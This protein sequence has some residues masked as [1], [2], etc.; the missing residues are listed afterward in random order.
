MTAPSVVAQVSKRTA[1]IAQ[2]QPGKNSYESGNFTQAARELQA[3]VANFAAKGAR[4]CITR[5]L[6][7]LFVS[8]GGGS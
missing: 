7:D 8:P 2:V 6:R 4:N 1:T 3:A 5:S